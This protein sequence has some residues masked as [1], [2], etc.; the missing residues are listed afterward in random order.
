MNYKKQIE[1]RKIHTKIRTIIYGFEALSPPIFARE[2]CRLSGERFLRVLFLCLAQNGLVLYTCNVTVRE[3]RKS[4]QNIIKPI[5]RHKMRG[6]FF[7][8]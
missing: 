3:R 1:Y 4:V 8:F 5:Q 2:L 6:V 7:F